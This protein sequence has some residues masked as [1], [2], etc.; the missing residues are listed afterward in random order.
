M[1]NYPSRPYNYYQEPELIQELPKGIQCVLKTGECF[2]CD[3]DWIDDTSFAI[4]AGWDK[5][6]NDPDP[7]DSFY[8]KGYRIAIKVACQPLNHDKWVRF[9]QD[10]DMP[11]LKDGSVWDTKLYLYSD[12]NLTDVAHDLYN[13]FWDKMKPYYRATGI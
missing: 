7:N 11:K 13:K 10:W 3:L 5:S 8:R 1:S 9:N 4:V 12:S 6:P 2:I